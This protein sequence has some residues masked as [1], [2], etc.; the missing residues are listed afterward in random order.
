VPPGETPPDTGSVTPGPKAA[1]SGKRTVTPWLI[2]G[3]VVLIALMFM[4]F[5]VFRVVDLTN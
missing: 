5:F 4:L 2:V 3:L 1:G